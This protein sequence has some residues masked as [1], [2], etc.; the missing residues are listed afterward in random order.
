MCARPV[1]QPTYNQSRPHGDRMR[2]LTSAQRSAINSKNKKAGTSFEDRVKAWLERDGWYCIQLRPKQLPNGKYIGAAEG[3]WIGLKRVQYDCQDFTDAILIEC[4]QTSKHM[5]SYQAGYK[6]AWSMLKPN[7]VATMKKVGEQ[8]ASV[9]LY[10]DCPE[11]ALEVNYCY[12]YLNDNG[13]PLV[14]AWEINKVTGKPIKEVE[15]DHQA[16]LPKRRKTKEAK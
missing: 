1:S 8:Y 16:A 10:F 9:S 4:K 2:T 3:D 7:Q 5:K 12:S 14:T 11:F 15:I 13:T 6:Q